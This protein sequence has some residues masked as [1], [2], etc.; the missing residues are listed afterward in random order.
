MAT[1]P[2]ALAGV[3][4]AIACGCNRYEIEPAL[5]VLRSDTAKLTV[6]DSV[7][8]GESFTV[9]VG[10]FGGGCTGEHA[11]QIARVR[12]DTTEIRP[13]MRRLVSDVCTSD[14]LILH[15]EVPV[16]FAAPG[17]A[18]VRVIG[19]LK[20]PPSDSGGQMYTRPVVLERRVRVVPA[21]G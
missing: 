10:V 21:P 18:L 6:P 4:L 19:V 12:G 7:I 8:T 1:I 15:Q 5:V 20:G 14:L 17:V 2:R 16:S 3:L 13:R 11:R 9:S